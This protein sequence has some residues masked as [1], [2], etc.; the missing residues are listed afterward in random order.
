M[1]LRTNSKNLDFHAHMNVRDIYIQPTADTIAKHMRMP[2]KQVISRRYD[3]TKRHIFSD[4]LCAPAESNQSFRKKKLSRMGSSGRD[5]VGFNS[6]LTISFNNL[7]TLHLKPH[8]ITLLKQ[9][10]FNKNLFF[11]NIYMGTFIRVF[12]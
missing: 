10:V 7:N 12:Q 9:T 6:I 3:I 11:F 1:M 8:H 2:T 5:P 4:T